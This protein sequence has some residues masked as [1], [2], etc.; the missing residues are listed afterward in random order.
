M[1]VRE[2]IPLVTLRVVTPKERRFHPD[3]DPILMVLRNLQA[4]NPKSYCGEVGL[5]LE[6]SR[7]PI[8]L[9]KLYQ[10]Y[11]PKVRDAMPYL[12]YFFS[13]LNT[14]TRTAFWAI[15]LK[16]S[17]GKYSPRSFLKTATALASDAIKYELTIEKLDRE[18]Q[19]YHFYGII[20]GLLSDLEETEFKKLNIP[21]P[22][23]R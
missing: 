20:R 1:K 7:G 19:N 6:C 3:L 17:G 11:F 2:C 12:F 15:A 13:S 10:S 8:A 23:K 14:G 5:R 16:E 21:N 9:G 22:W 4:V 18:S